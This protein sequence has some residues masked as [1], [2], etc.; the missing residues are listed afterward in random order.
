MIRPI[1]TTRTLVVNIVFQ[2]LRVE[3]LIEQKVD[4]SSAAMIFGIPAQALQPPNS[5]VHSAR[6]RCFV[7][8]NYMKTSFYWLPASLW[9]SHPLVSGS[10]S[11]FPIKKIMLQFH[12]IKLSWL[13]VIFWFILEMIEISWSSLYSLHGSLLIAMTAAK[14]TLA[15]FLMTRGFSNG[16]RPRWGDADWWQKKKILL[17]QKKVSG[18]FISSEPGLFL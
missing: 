9:M 3:M 7:N 5:W 14:K 1:R 12:S 8:D 15:A 16:Q 11:N 10:K 4:V 17:L 13:L 6:S 2:S 18:I